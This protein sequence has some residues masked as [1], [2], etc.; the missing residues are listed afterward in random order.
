MTQRDDRATV[1][2]IIL[3][4]RDIQEF[5]AELDRASLVEDRL[6]RSAVVRQ[7]EIIGEATKRLS[8]D[9]R[10]RFREVPR[11]AMAG[12]RDRLIHGYHEV[13][14]DT[15]WQVATQE[16]PRLI[17]QLGDVV[18]VPGDLPRGDDGS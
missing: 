1:L 18:P 12:M 13:D 6:V 9:F 11:S 17:D 15:V 2:D 8:G 10:A 4:A 16:V 7:L 14:Y 3:A 5:V